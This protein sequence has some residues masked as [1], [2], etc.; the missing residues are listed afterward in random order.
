MKKDER[1][2]KWK[3]D[4]TAEQAMRAAGVRME[5]CCPRCGAKHPF[6]TYSCGPWMDGKT[7]DIPTHLSHDHP[8]EDDGDTED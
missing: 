1:A 4:T 3:P 6:H 7:S 2:K 8:T 5:S